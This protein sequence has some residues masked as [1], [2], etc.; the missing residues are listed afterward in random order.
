[1]PKR[2]LR[3]LIPNVTGPTN[4]GDQAILGGTLR[5]LRKIYPDVRITLHSSDVELYKTYQLDFPAD[6]IDHT[7]YHWA[8]FA[9]PNFITR[10]WRLFLLGI[11]YLR[12]SF[13]FFHP[14]EKL[15][16]TTL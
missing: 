14:K 15:Q 10:I 2:P 11:Y 8:V 12:L 6:V 16:P 13:G 9:R 3:L 4:M 7:L 5:L 1:M